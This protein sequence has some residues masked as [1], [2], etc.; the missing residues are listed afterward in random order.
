MPPF[1]PWG[2]RF[3]LFETITDRQHLRWL[4]GV[5][6]NTFSNCLP[7]NYSKLKCQKYILHDLQSTKLWAQRTSFIFPQDLFSFLSRDFLRFMLFAFYTLFF[8]QDLRG[9]EK[10]DS[11]FIQ[12]FLWLE[13][14]TLIPLLKMLPATQQPYKMALTSTS[15]SAKTSGT[16]LKQHLGLHNCYLKT[17]LH[18]CSFSVPSEHP[19]P[20]L[21]V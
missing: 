12:L 17:N 6:L 13:N 18:S 11:P 10:E 20:L 21:H 7:P 3:F 8:T 14:F 9:W 5:K 16:P 1:L 4:A 15:S 2:L 19:N